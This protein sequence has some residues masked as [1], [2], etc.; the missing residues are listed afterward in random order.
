MLLV[1]SAE[2]SLTVEFATLETFYTKM[3][4]ESTI[5]CIGKRKNEM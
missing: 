1:D 5:I 4:L 2:I 3:V